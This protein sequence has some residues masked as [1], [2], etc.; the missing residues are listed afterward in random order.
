MLA[1]LAQ[2]L[3]Q[4]M[5]LGE[6]FQQSRASLKQQKENLLRAQIM[7]KYLGR[8]QAA[9][10]QALEFANTQAQ[11]RAPTRGPVDRNRDAGTPDRPAGAMGPGQ[12]P[13]G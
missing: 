12:S 13:P 11:A 4:G 7:D 3:G 1:G 10:T 5:Q 2:G 9:R 8:Q 6:Q